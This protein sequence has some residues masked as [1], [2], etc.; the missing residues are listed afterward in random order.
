MV[1]PLFLKFVGKNRVK[2]KKIPYFGDEFREI[3]LIFNV[4]CWQ[5]WPGSVHDSRF[6][7]DLC[8]LFERG[9]ENINIKLHYIHLS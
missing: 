7:R 1:S 6:F 4:Q 2:E 8:T 9:K 3:S 5:L